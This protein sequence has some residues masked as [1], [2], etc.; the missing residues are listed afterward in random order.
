MLHVKLYIFTD[1]CKNTFFKFVITLIHSLFQKYIHFKY[2]IYFICTYNYKLLKNFR[3]EKNKQLCGH[4]MCWFYN[5]YLVFSLLDIGITRCETIL[6]LIKDL[7]MFI[8]KYELKQ[9]ERSVCLFANIC[10]NYYLL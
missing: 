7:S 10:R 6:I 3:I 9:F 2:N 1:F 4:C 5:I 8:F